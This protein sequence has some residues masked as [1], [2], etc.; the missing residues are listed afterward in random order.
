MLE[1]IHESLK[2]RMTVDIN[3]HFEVDLFFKGFLT[4]T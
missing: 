3:M 4:D 1:E 2:F